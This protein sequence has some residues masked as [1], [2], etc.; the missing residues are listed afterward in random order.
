MDSVK[1]RC[2]RHII[3]GVIIWYHSQPPMKHNTKAPVTDTLAGDHL[4]YVLHYKND[5]R[6]VKWF[7]LQDGLPCS[8]P[9][10]FAHSHISSLL[11]HMPPPP[12]LFQNWPNFDILQA[13][14]ADSL[15]LSSI[16]RNRG[17]LLSYA[18]WGGYWKLLQQPYSPSCKWF[19]I[20]Q[21]VPL[22][23][24]PSPWKS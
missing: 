2:V 3:F 21:S 16:C 24:S 13:C 12:L 4:L 14:H 5:F 6:S 18:A 11:L 20:F 7:D 15:K 9:A 23:Y 19:P 1:T 8:A 22:F 10:S 17:L